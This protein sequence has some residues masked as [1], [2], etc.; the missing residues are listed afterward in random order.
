MHIHFLWRV[1]HIDPMKLTH[2]CQHCTGFQE[3]Q[4]VI[5][6]VEINYGEGPDNGPPLLMMH[7]Q[8]VT[9]LSYAK[10]LPELSR[11]FHIFAPDCHGH[12]KTDRA[13]EKRTA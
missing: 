6:S 9:W 10:V 3:K 5:N 13:P 7:A 2:D 1:S 4:V 8:N 12:G 11:S